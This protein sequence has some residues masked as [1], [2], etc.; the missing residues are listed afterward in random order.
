MENQDVINVLFLIYSIIL[1]IILE[2]GALFLRVKRKQKER[3]KEI[4]LKAM[5]NGYYNNFGQGDDKV[6]LKKPVMGSNA[7]LDR[8]L[9]KEEEK[10]VEKENKE[11]KRC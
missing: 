1:G 2:V 11:N 7:M 9:A 4:Q 6:K 5:G 8:M 3:E 10:Q